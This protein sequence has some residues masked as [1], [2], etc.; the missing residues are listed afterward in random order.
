MSRM[1]PLLDHHRQAGALLAPYGP[2]SAPE[3]AVPLVE[4]F[5]PVP[6]EYAA[7]RSKVA[8]FDQA[9]R[10]TLALTGADRLTFLNRMVTQELDP[11]R[12][13][14]PFT[15]RRSFWLNRKGRI[16]ADLRILHMPDRLLIDVDI[17]A[18][19]RAKAGLDGYIIT[20]DCTLTD[21]TDRW[22]RL[23]LHG[24]GAAALLSRVGRLSEPGASTSIAD[25]QLGQV[26]LVRIGE[27]EVV[28]DRQDSTGE[29]GLEL[30]V[31]IGAVAE[32][33]AALIG[34]GAKPSGWHALNIARIEAGTP[35]YYVD[36]GPDSLPHE[37]GEATLHDRVSFKK[38]CY[39]GQEVVA[40]MNALGHPKQR[41]VGLKV[42]GAT[43]GGG[44]L[45][46]NGESQQLG[47][48]PQAITGTP[49]LASE[50][51]DA[52][53]IGAVTSSCISPMLGDT[54]IA[55]AMVKWAHSNPGTVL[56][57]DVGGTRLKAD[58]QPS[59]TFWQRTG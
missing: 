18:A 41:L 12:G 11:A 30:L 58:T 46:A 44:G 34:Q 10:A 49:V 23:A 21:E 39:L 48:S 3:A 17:H 14:A 16:D 42:Q 59:L 35:M 24:P 13:F 1:F 53:P 20:E 8:L 9:H 7:I 45:P 43:V 19:A 6:I 54:P 31:P 37:A 15:M 40:R 4:A 38:G 51:S 36:F 5:G 33:Y 50:A 26:A 28:V 52:Q 57:L 27:A 55:F 22:H 56:F 29:I 47:G 25:I 32:V 2:A